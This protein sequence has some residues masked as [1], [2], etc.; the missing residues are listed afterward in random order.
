MAAAAVSGGLS[1]FAAQPAS[2]VVGTSQRFDLGGNGGKFFVNI[3]LHQPYWAM[4]SFAFDHVYG[5]IY[6]VQTKVGSENGDLWVTRTDMTGQ[7]LGAMAIHGFDHGSNIAI[8]PDTYGSPYMWVP[9]D[10]RDLHP[11]DPDSKPNSHTIAR[12]KYADGGDLTYSNSAV[13]KFPI[14]LSDFYDCPRPAIDP[15]NN[16]IL[17][18]YMESAT[19]WRLAL[20]DLPSVL[21]NGFVDDKPTRLA[22]RALPS[23]SEIG[24]TAEDAFQGVTAYGQY[25]Y[26]LYGGHPEKT[27]DPAVPSY[28][29][30][31][32][33]NAVGTSV[34]E[35]FQTHAGDTLLPGREPQ[36]IA[37]YRSSVGP[38]LAFGFSSKYDSE[39]P[40]QFRSTVFYKTDLKT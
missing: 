11:E 7:V 20:F 36:G 37:V 18:R 21:S 30:T 2:A 28:L 26:L 23:N 40:A 31:L 6:Y 9:G 14:H 39:N 8:E 24:L 25:A 22:A 5:H 34:K 16:R 1:V 32:D 33:M 13:R 4:Q 15:Y 19:R 12:F 35:V 17:L 38:Q 27:T 3:P 29:V 10:W